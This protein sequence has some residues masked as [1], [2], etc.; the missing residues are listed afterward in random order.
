MQEK[1]FKLGMRSNPGPPDTQGSPLQRAAVNGDASVIA[2]LVNDGVDLN[3]RL[4]QGWTALHIA[5]AGNFPD[6]VDGLLQC[7]ADWQMAI[8]DGSTAL[9]MA[10][11]NG[12][13]RVVEVLL[14][15]AARA[16]LKRSS[17][18]LEP[19]H[20]AAGRGKEDVLRVLIEAYIQCGM[21]IDSTAN[22]GGT[23]LEFACHGGYIEC[24][25]ML[26]SAGANVDAVVDDRGRTPLMN[27]ATTDKAQV[28]RVLLDA[29][30][31]IDRIHYTGI[32]AVQIA[33]FTGSLNILR[34]LIS[35]GANLDHVD[36]RGFT[37]L[38]AAL[39]GQHPEAAMILLKQRIKANRAYGEKKSTALHLAVSAGYLDV[40]EALI[41]KGVDIDACDADGDTPLQWAV[42]KGSLEIVN[43]LLRNGAQINKRNE[44]TG[45][46]VLH[47]AVK[48]GHV[49]ITELLLARRADPSLIDLDVIQIHKSAD[50]EQVET[51]KALI[52]T[53][54]SPDNIPDIG[55]IELSPAPKQSPTSTGAELQLK[56]SVDDAKYEQRDTDISDRIRHRVLNIPSQIAAQDIISKIGD[57]VEHHGVTCDGPLCKKTSESIKGVRFRCCWCENV[58]FCS[59]CMSSFHNNHDPTHPM[60]HCLIPTH[61]HTVQEMDDASKRSCLEAWG[62]L[63]ISIEDL[64]H[65][66]YAFPDSESL[67]VQLICKEHHLQDKEVRRLLQDL[68]PAVFPVV[69]STF[70]ESVSAGFRNR[71]IIR[72][73]DDTPGTM[74]YYKIDEVGNVR[75]KRY[76]KEMTPNTVRDDDAV[77]HYR[78]PELLTRVLMGELQ[79]Y[80]YSADRKHKDWAWQGRFVTRLVDIKPGNFDDKLEIDIRVV[81]L[82]SWPAYE[83]L[84]YT[85]KETAYE[86]AIVP[87][88]SREE[89]ETARKMARFLHGVYCKDKSGNE[90]Y[91]TVNCGLRDALKQVRHSSE[92]KTYWIDQLSINQSNFAERR[93]AVTGMMW[94]FNRARQVTL[95]VG[96]ED[97]RTR[98]VFDVFWKIVHRVHSK[99]C[100]PDPD[101]MLADP[102]LQLPSFD[103]PVWRSAGDFF[104]RP[105]FS[106]CWV[107][108]EVVVG[109][110]VMVQCGEFTMEWADLARVAHTFSQRSWLNKLPRDILAASAAALSNPLAGIKEE[111]ARLGGLPSV[112]MMNG[113]RE[114]FQ[115]LKINSVE[116]LLYMTS[117]FHAQEPRDQIYSVLGLQGASLSRGEA[118]VVKPDY[119]KPVEDV[120]VDAARACIMQSSSLTICG[121]KDCAS[122]PMQESLPSWVPDFT[123]TALTS[124]TSLCRP[125]PLRPY[126]ACGDT[127]L[128]AAWPY[129]ERQDLL[130]I[131]S[132]NIE[133]VVSVSEYLPW[134]ERALENI[135]M[136]WTKLASTVGRQYP[137]GEFAPDAFVRTCVVDTSGSLRQSPMP[138]EYH[139]SLCR[140]FERC[141]SHHL[142][143]KCAGLDTPDETILR[144]CT[145]PLIAT[146][147]VD[148]YQ[149]ESPTDRNEAEQS[150]T[151]SVDTTV[152]GT[153]SGG[154]TVD[155]D[156]VEALW[157]ACHNR[158]FFV[159]G[160]G[161]FGLGPRDLRAGDEVHILGGTPVPFILRPYVAR[162]GGPAGPDEDRRT[163][164]VLDA[165]GEDDLKLYRMVGECYIHGY[166]HG[167]VATRNDVEW[168]GV[169]IF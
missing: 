12:H 125:V 24:V 131:S 126:N 79:P 52:F 169:G 54:P 36:N 116:N 85:W 138:R 55:E 111:E 157:Q 114:D 8:E 21:D 96:D 51:C 31:E 162:T 106:R 93:F 115:T 9:H 166:M 41:G 146:L 58:D 130:V 46:V 20:I 89:V 133:N 150:A 102:E 66:V 32:T 158:R 109:R 139:A 2:N 164:T 160:N 167:Q 147:I 100:L 122:S 43:S 74:A 107:I 34:V 95:W 3:A 64:S 22:D 121:L 99:G 154:A 86:R 82:D 90:R 151:A 73:G 144:D 18:G 42:E 119:E 70:E 1:F 136:K 80:D 59:S 5:A 143:L 17:D 92:T 148:T 84:S 37:P 19:L 103:S 140:L 112:V 123:T 152:G 47:W 7:A 120:F 39:V 127:S 48:C 10:A 118:S 98:D 11:T 104:N 60:I 75:M 129:E 45:E 87:S 105:V 33:A 83:A 145:N 81:D 56:D 62:D 163:P 68:D 71:E 69:R 141:Y 155:S 38:R 132:C 117:M 161:F 110:K 53:A 40:V 72:E 44:S 113:L 23:A 135:V 6:F 26:V 108:Q 63:S 15:H 149:L 25:K 124:T 67:Q 101:E 94:Y 65:I 16:N 4:D 50:E 35:E 153:S 168:E 165:I 29:G 77:L 57:S 159:T 134:G 78:D 142:S 30:A 14:S 76:H 28:A 61:F 27:A 128:V 97:E 91:L 13:H 137:T 156:A 88:W 49:G